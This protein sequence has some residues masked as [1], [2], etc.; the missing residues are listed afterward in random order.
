MT[1]ARWV[2]VAG[3][4][5][6]HA[7]APESS[8]DYFEARLPLALDP[9]KGDKIHKEGIEEAAVAIHA[10]RSG[11][12]HHVRREATGHSEFL[13]GNGALWDVKSPLSPPADASGWLFD[14]QHQVDVVRHELD[15]DEGVLLNLTRCTPEDT[16]ALQGALRQ[17]LQPWECKKVYV[18]SNPAATQ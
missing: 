13:D 3:Q 16:R 5:L 1:A 18:L 12:L 17:A 11:V 7:P 10:D 14:V 15:G 6:G 8:P 4:P 9:A 2:D